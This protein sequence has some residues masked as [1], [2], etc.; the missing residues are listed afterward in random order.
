MEFADKVDY[1][2]RK[3]LDVIFIF[4]SL[5][6][7]QQHTPITNEDKLKFWAENTLDALKYI[8]SLGVIHADLKLENILIQTSEYE[9]EYPI[10]KL[11]DFG[12]SHIIDHNA[13]N[14]SYMEMKCGTF[15]YIAPEV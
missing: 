14:K 2:S 6:N 12:L 8:H 3:I 9:D 7:K 1:L 11:C 4:K 10:T 5:I 13:G 15:G